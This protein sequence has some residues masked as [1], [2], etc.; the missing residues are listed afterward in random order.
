M[1]DVFQKNEIRNVK[2][3]RNV[4]KSVKYFVEKNVN[5]EFKKSV[6]I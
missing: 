6:N 2:F 4:L 1:S 3:L 5:K